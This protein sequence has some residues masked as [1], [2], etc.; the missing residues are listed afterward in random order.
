MS[1]FVGYQGELPVMVGNTYAEVE[2]TPHMEFDRIEEVDDAELFNGE[3]LIGEQIAFRKNAAYLHSLRLRR[4]SL[5]AETDYL[6]QPDYPIDSDMLE[7][8]KAYRQYLR[9]LPSL[10]GAP[11]DG[12]G[13]ETPWPANPLEA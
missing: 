2:S 10:E 5:L 1:K 7:Q 11:W 13:P 8:V 12:G 6:V 9:D 3:V 4:D